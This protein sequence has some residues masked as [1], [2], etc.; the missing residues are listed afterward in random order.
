MRNFAFLDF[1]ECEAIRYTC[2]YTYIIM[3][4]LSKL[5]NISNLML[6]TY[7]NLYKCYDTLALTSSTDN[8]ETRNFAFYTIVTY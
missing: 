8:H 4:V 1:L 6:N 5:K 3:L 7:L 2:I